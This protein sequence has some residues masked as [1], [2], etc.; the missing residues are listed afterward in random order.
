[1]ITVGTDRGKS[2]VLYGFHISQ[3]AIPCSHFGLMLGTID[4]S[5]ATSRVT[6]VYAAN[7]FDGSDLTPGIH[8]ASLTGGGNQINA[9]YLIGYYVGGAAS[10]SVD[11]KAFASP[12]TATV[13]PWSVNPDVKFWWV[14]GT[15]AVPTFGQLHATDANGTALPI[16]THGQQSVG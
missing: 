13:V 16:G 11:E 3:A 6:G 10:V 5:G 9:W 2:V 8:A 1:M 4:S 12:V 7:E 14:S 15:G